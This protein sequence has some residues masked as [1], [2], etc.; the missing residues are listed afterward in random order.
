M[1]V[2]I[3]SLL[4][5]RERANDYFHGFM[6]FYCGNKSSFVKGQKIQKPSVSLKG[7]KLPNL[8]LNN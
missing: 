5:E 7:D 6:K 3:T 4:C 1:Q 2:N 8:Y